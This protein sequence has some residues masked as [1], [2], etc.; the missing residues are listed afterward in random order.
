MGSMKTAMS[1]LA[2]LAFSMS[3]PDAARVLAEMR[4]AIGGDSAIAAVL[5]FSVRGSES[6]NFDGRTGGGD[7]E[8]ICALP[9]RFLRV[10]RVGSPF[11]ISVEADGFNGDARIRRRDSDIPS[12]PDPYQNDTP[13]QRA[14]R[15]ARAVRNTK[16]ELSRFA[17]ALLGV[18]AI[19]SL[20]TSYVAQ[21]NVNGKPCDVLRL[22]SADGYTATLAV[23]A[24]THLPVV[25]SW[26]AP[27]IVTFTTTAAVVVPRGQSP[28]AV[29]PPAPPSLPPD[30]TAGLADV[31]HQ[32]WF[33]DFKAADGL[34]WPHRFI[35]KVGGRVWTTT[36]LG[37]YKLNPKIDPKQFDPARR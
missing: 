33:E 32:L 31:E 30:P 27:P 13:D 4:Q 25:V 37:K 10:R 15:N 5:A 16:H 22:R 20:D 36:Q 26:M 29:P 19:D 34:T 21:Q 17:V 1:A 8:W 24:A 18:T 12:P 28:G 3:Q 2:A 7:I 11:G 9:D 6:R 23:D 14:A 35:E